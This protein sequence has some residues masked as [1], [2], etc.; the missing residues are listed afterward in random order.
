MSSSSGRPSLVQLTESSGGLALVGQR[1]TPR[2]PLGRWVSGSIAVTRAGSAGT[3]ASRARVRAA[4]PCVTPW[5]GHRVAQAHQAL[6]QHRDEGRGRR[7]L[8]QPVAGDA[9]VFAGVVRGRSLEQEAPVHQDA[10]A[11]LEAAAR[12]GR[13]QWRWDRPQE[14]STHPA[15]P[16][17]S[18]PGSQW[19]RP[20]QYQPVATSV[21][22]RPHRT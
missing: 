21:P 6:T 3:K 8:P 13:G 19:P 18:D 4:G 14:D 9:G 5:A 15:S 20:H 11:S 22:P 12:G 2:I 17:R 7:R 1:I 10:D 16:T